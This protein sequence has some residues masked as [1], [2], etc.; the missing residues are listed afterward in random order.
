LEKKHPVK[1]QDGYSGVGKKLGSQT[2]K[3]PRGAPNSG[4]EVG[5]TE[6]KLSPIQRHPKKTAQSR[7]ERL[8][9]SEKS[10]GK[11]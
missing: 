2:N 3:R 5:P 8:G 6:Q 1:V 4:Q 9:A 7:R 11:P 10:C